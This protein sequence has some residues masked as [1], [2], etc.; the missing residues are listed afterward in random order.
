MT[1][2]RLF[3]LPLTATT[4]TVVVPGK[5]RALSAWGADPGPITTGRG[6]GRLEPRACQ[7]IAA[8]GYGSRRS[9]GRHRGWS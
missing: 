4:K 2:E 9:P 3:G 7:P 8:G 6:M 1:I 5:P